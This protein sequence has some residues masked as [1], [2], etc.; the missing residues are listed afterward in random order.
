MGK[1]GLHDKNSGLGHILFKVVNAEE[2]ILTLI[3]KTL[4][5][6]TQ[7]TESGREKSYWVTDNALKI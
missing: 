2:G 1:L 7:E 4:I 6:K 3:F 5:F